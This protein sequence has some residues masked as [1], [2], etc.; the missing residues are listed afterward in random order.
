MTAARELRRPVGAIAF[1]AGWSALLFAFAAPGAGA[2]RA[3]PVIVVDS[4]SVSPGQNVLVALHAWPE[5]PVTVAV[6]GNGGIRGS[7]DCDQIGAETVPIGASGTQQLRLTITVPP[8]GCPCVIRGNTSTSDVVR[9]APIDIAGV[10]G[11]VH[12]LPASGPASPSALSASVHISSPSQPWPESWYPPFAGNTARAVMLTLTN[13]GT[14]TMT[15]LRVVSEVGRAHQSGAPI[16]P[17]VIAA[18]APGERRTVSMPFVIDAPVYGT[19]VV[20]GSVYGLAA[21]VTFRASTSNDP[22]AL[23]LVPVIV[24]LVVAQILRQRERSKQRALAELEQQQAARAA[25]PQ[26]SPEVGSSYGERSGADPYH[27][28]RYELPPRAR[29]ADDR[30]AD[31][32]GVGASSGG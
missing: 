18:L 21:P 9:A 10:P 6:C 20:T 19:Y 11:G 25:L 5:G 30:V 3:D 17:A 15:G 7:E 26:S 27:H 22:W 14:T 32:L 29:V 16:P 24:L 28:P 4:S 1:A 8:V 31:A 23:E 2:A 12:L 13:T